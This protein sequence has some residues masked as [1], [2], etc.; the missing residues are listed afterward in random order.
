MKRIV[1]LIV[2]VM[3]SAT[4]TFA[5]QRNITGK[6]IDSDTKEAIMQTTVQLLKNDSAF[7]GGGV[8]TEDGVFSVKAPSNGKYI[9]KI[10]IIK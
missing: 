2:I 6:I 10:Y 9:I 3:I 4:Y 7:V 1:T 8:T 5:Q